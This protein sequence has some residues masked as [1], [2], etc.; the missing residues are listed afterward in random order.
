MIIE[1]ITKIN[2]QTN[3]LITNDQH[4]DHFTATLSMS[5]YQIGNISL[6]TINYITSELVRLREGC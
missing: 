5:H 3:D 2:D 1:M 4:N 6:I